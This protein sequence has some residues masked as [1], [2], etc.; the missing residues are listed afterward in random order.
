MGC[1]AHPFAAL[2]SRVK[3]N[4]LLDTKILKHRF[5]RI[6]RRSEILLLKHGLESLSLNPKLFQEVAKEDPNG[7][8]LTDDEEKL[9]PTGFLSHRPL[10]RLLILRDVIEAELVRCPQAYKEFFLVS[11]SFVVANGAGNFAF[12]PEIYRTKPKPDYDVLGH[13]ARHTHKMIAELTNADVIYTY[14]SRRPMPSEILDSGNSLELQSSA[15][16]DTRGNDGAIQVPAQRLK[17]VR[18]KHAVPDVPG[19]IE[20]ADG[21]ALIVFLD[22]GI[23]GKLPEVISAVHVHGLLRMIHRKTDP[24]HARGQAHAFDVGEL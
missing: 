16:L 5:A 8:A 3:T 1:D 19:M 9:L 21:F 24:S 18:R 10:Q 22:Q 14:R 13:F 4:W 6:L 2:V 23:G 15:N 17:Q 20:G 12:G 11:L 7:Y